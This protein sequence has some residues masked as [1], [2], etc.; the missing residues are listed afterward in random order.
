M[1]K[2]GRYGSTSEPI[3]ASLRHFQ[4]CAPTR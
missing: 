3:R 1:L 2:D 4:A